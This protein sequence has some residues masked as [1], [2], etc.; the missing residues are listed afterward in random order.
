MCSMG[1]RLHCE[2]LTQ[3]LMNSRRRRRRPTVENAGSCWAAIPCLIA[4]V[5]GRE[6]MT[7]LILRILLGAPAFRVRPLAASS[8]RHAFSRRSS[9]GSK[10]LVSEVSPLAVLS[11]GP[12]GSLQRL[13]TPGLGNCIGPSKLGRYYHLPVN[14]TQILTD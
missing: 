9:R 12:Y 10:V 4:T 11:M 1:K 13:G 7:A 8:A 5:S 6:S 3:I 14:W 2:E